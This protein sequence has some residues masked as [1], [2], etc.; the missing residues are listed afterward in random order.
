MSTTSR[1]VYTES[2]YLV[3]ASSFLPTHK[4]SS[5]EV[6]RPNLGQIWMCGSRFNA[7]NCGKILNNFITIRNLLIF[8]LCLKTEEIIY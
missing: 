8:I 2:A 7:A 5:I 3:P 1:Y 4:T 6:I